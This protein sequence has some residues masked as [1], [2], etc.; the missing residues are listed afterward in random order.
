MLLWYVH[1]T[2]IYYWITEFSPVRARC[3]MAFTWL[4]AFAWSLRFCVREKR[5]PESL[6]GCSRPTCRAPQ[7]QAREDLDAEHAA[8]Y[9][10]EGGILLTPTLDCG[11]DFL[12]KDH[13][14]SW[15]HIIK[16]SSRY[17]VFKSKQYHGSIQRVYS[18]TCT[19][20]NSFKEKKCMISFD[21][22]F[23]NF[24]LLVGLQLLLWY[25]FWTW[26]PSGKSKTDDRILHST[27]Y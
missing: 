13:T 8:N 1:N 14:G 18:P 7:W 25:H 23:R 19:V 16:A 12:A 5:R 22:S 4:V 11:V 17:S 10:S 6:R 20:S 26:F 9:V 15:A 21:I 27:K 3:A 2:N 24:T